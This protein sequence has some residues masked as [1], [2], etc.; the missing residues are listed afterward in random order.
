MIFDGRIALVLAGYDAGENPSLPK[1]NNCRTDAIAPP[2]VCF[3]G[4]ALR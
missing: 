3:R 1:A 4:P 2:N